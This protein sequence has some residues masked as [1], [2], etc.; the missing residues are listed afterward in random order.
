MKHIP[1]IP[2]KVMN[3]ILKFLMLFGIP[4]S[5]SF[6]LG[7]EMKDNQI[8]YIP[9]VVADYD[10]SAFSRML[11]EEIRSNN[12]FDIK[13]YASSDAEV[14][15]LIDENKARVGVM[16]PANFA[17][18]L[19]LGKEPKVLLLYDGSQM[20]I[21]SAAK[22][23]MSEILLSIK[24]GFLV[25][26][27]E[28]KA[29]VMPAQAMEAAMPM[30]FTYRIWNNPTRN[31]KNFLLPPILMAIIQ[32]GLVMIGAGIP[33]KDNLYVVVFLKN[34]LYG[35]LGTLS[36]ILTLGVQVFYFG[37]PYRG[38]IIG[39]FLLVFLYALGI[40]AFGILIRILLRNELFSTQ[41]AAVIMLP[42][43]IIGGLTWPLVAMPEKYQFAGSLYPY[44]HFAETLR[45]LC[46]K[47]IG[48]SYI[49]PEIYWLFRFVLWMWGLSLAFYLIRYGK[50]LFRRRAS[51]HW[52]NE[53]N[54]EAVVKL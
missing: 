1:H 15:Q 33:K 6:L 2:K 52:I 14:K 9:T 5:V 22:V 16:I 35:F 50:R 51:G 53:G 47:D 21:T 24:A 20:S 26:I 25:K 8:Q 41:V 29:G 36:I 28:G 18:D 11:I 10:G 54:Q 39:G 37:V 31:Y 27:M 23:R 34:L 44:M 4:I 43:S 46:V 49:I 7:Y 13:Y 38:S 30:H 19:K 45:D 40:V 42:S 3:V 17:E 12:I 48:I 32:V